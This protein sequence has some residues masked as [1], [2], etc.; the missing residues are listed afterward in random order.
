M[1]REKESSMERK[2]VGRNR[3]GKGGKEGTEK[4]EERKE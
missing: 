3:G 4:R 2:K 1:E